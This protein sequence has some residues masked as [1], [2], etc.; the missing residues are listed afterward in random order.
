MGYNISQL[1]NYTDQQSR[2]FV[3]KSI[4]EADTI[5]LLTSA[6]SF[7]PTA[8]GNQAIQLLDTDVYFQD[9]SACGRNALGGANFSQATLSVKD[10]KVNQNYCVRDLEKTYAVEDLKAKMKGQV[11]TDALFLDT[12]GNLNAEK[13]S[14][15][16]EQILW[17]GDV[18]ITGSTNLN[19]IDGLLKSIKSGN[20]YINLSAVTSGATVIEKLQ[21]VFASMPIEVSS[22]PDFKILIGKDIWN[23]YQA[24]IAAKNLFNPNDP[25]T[26]W[27]TD[28]KLEVVNG[29]NG[30]GYVVACR[31]RNLQ[32]GGEM[33]NVSFNK[34]Y[35]Y[36]TEQVYLDSRFSLGVVAV[37]PQEI[38]L[39]K[40]S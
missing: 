20:T 22:K 5:K 28:A 2:V 13:T 36:E 37:Y 34:H 18:N 33:T 11:Y 30:T 14:Y 16:L 27:G 32:A 39:V 4:L 23:S 24:A 15:S 6:G 31:L 8:K 40:I 3:T 35:S 1:P 26:L 17:Q 9:G 38:G 7:D 21:G 10:M 19:M 25:K 29:L 12:I